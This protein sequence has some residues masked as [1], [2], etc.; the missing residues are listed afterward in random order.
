[1]AGYLLYVR[2]GRLALLHRICVTRE[3]REKVVGKC[4]VHS[5]R[6]FLQKGAAKASIFEST[7]LAGRREHCTLRAASNNSTVYSTIT[8]RGE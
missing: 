2:V 1:V 3:E 6:Q 8:A 4:L 7:R 5:L